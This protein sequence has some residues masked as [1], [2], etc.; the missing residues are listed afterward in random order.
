MNAAYPGLIREFYRLERQ[1][2]Q[3]TP[4]RRWH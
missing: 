2:G 1:Q 4:R 3:T